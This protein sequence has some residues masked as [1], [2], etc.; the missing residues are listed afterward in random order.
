MSN[1]DKT[2]QYVLDVHM[3]SPPATPSASRDALQG[4]SR[5]TGG[6]LRGRA[7]GNVFNHAD[8]EDEIQ[9]VPR[10]GKVFIYQ[11]PQDPMAHKPD[12]SIV[13]E[14]TPQLKPI[15]KTL[16]RKYSPVRSE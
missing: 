3:A 14:V 5:M 11:S 7:L 9:V 1:M 13:S 12:M 6:I 10:K 16:A 2:Y 4:A 8:G 15:L